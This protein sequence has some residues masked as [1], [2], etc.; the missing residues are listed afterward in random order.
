M[1]ILF[2]EIPADGASYKI[3]DLELS[4]PNEDFKVNSPVGINCFLAA[5]NSNSVAIKG[6]VTASLSLFCACCLDEFSL[7]LR[8]EFS[9]VLVVPEDRSWHLKDVDVAA[10]DLDLLELVE[11]VIDLAEIARQQLFYELP[12]KSVCSSDCRGLCP[13][14]G[15]NLNSASCVCEKDYSNSPF[16]A[17]AGVKGYVKK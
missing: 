16:A 15:V 2:A 10:K 17:L 14:C 12:L 1:K 9:F 6:E 4:F 3:P 13:G 7:Q 11:P 8:S 5:K